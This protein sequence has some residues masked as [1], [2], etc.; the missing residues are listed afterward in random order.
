L[1]I[2]WIGLSVMEGQHF[3]LSTAALTI[4]EYESSQLKVAVI[5]LGS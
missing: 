3:H 5:E 4:L 1:A 2:R